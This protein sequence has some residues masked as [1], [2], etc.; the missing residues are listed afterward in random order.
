[1]GLFQVNTFLYAYKLLAKI[2]KKINSAKFLPFYLHSYM[3][4]F[5]YSDTH[6]TS[7]CSSPVRPR[8]CEVTTFRGKMLVKT[9]NFL[10]VS[11]IFCSIFF[12]RFF[13]DLE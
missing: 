3:L 1:M 5:R 10:H 12:N 8:A 4:F 13:A 6:F 11:L 9:Y 7:F 2:Q